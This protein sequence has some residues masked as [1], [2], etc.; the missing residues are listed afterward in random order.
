MFSCCIRHGKYI[1][2]LWHSQARYPHVQTPTHSRLLPICDAFF[3][4][5]G[6]RR[7][8]PILIGEESDGGHRIKRALYIGIKRLCPKSQSL[9]TDMRRLFYSTWP[10]SF[11]SFLIGEESD[12]GHRIKR[13]L[14]IGIKRLCPKYTVGNDLLKAKPKRQPSLGSMPITTVGKVW[15]FSVSR[16]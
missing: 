2:C 11:S 13:A 1:W 5:R 15:K 4:Q 14:Y 10:P 16:D 7:S 3:I 12:G 8:L 9:A 6:H